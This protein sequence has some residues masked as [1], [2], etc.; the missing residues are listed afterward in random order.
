MKITEPG[1]IQKSKKKEKKGGRKK[2]SWLYASD[3]GIKEGIKRRKERRSHGEEVVQN[4]MG[5]DAGNDFIGLWGSGYWL[6]TL[7]V[8]EGFC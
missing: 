3:V 5:S 6:M 4:H 1:I 8:S 7:G 2:R